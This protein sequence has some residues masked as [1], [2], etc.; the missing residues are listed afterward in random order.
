MVEYLF[1]QHEILRP[2]NNTCNY[3]TTRK[4]MY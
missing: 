4:E 1:D 2:R 3:S